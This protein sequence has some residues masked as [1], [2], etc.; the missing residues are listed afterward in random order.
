MRQFEA[1]KPRDAWTK[2][3]SLMRRDLRT[4]D[5]RDLHP[6]CQPDD[7][8]D[9]HDRRRHEGRDD[10][11]QEDLREAQQRIDE[12]HQQVIDRRRRNSRQRAR[13]ACR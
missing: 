13:P 1:P 2:S 5:A 11:Q 4:D 8:R 10:Q 3:I 9:R 12:A 6:R 7:Q